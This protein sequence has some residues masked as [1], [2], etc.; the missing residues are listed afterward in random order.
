MSYDEIIELF[1]SDKFDNDVWDKIDY[2]LSNS[3]GYSSQ[4]LI[5]IYDS[6]D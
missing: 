4:E 5:D 2:I 3:K 6:L 1:N